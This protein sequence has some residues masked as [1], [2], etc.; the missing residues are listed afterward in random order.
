MHP[1][2]G[3]TLLFTT[4]QGTRVPYVTQRR[5]YYAQNLCA[6]QPTRVQKS[7]TADSAKEHIPITLYVMNL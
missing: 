3:T 5:L 2:G 4:E 1:S 6:L 7:I